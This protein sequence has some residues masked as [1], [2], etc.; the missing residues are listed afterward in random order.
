MSPLNSAGLQSDAAS[1]DS[2]PPLRMPHSSPR[3]VYLQEASIDIAEGHG[4]SGPPLL[5][6]AQLADVR[7]PMAAEANDNR[8]GV[9]VVLSITKLGTIRVA[10]S[11]CLC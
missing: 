2:R 5:E 3:E 8:R 10:A 7:L 6:F 1:G 11:I 9:F 4:A